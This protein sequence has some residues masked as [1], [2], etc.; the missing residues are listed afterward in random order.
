MF[1][2]RDRFGETRTSY[3]CWLTHLCYSA[4]CTPAQLSLLSD[5]I[6]RYSALKHTKQASPEGKY[7]PTALILVLLRHCCDLKNIFNPF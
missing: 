4:T 6:A 2:R 3:E 7:I 5:A 1:G